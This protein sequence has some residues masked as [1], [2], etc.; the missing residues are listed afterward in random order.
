MRVVVAKS[1]SANEPQVRIEGDQA[2]VKGT[3]VEG[4][5]GEYLACASDR[6]QYG[7]MNRGPFKCCK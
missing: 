1:R 6:D 5:E 3:V 7:P 4:V 2:E